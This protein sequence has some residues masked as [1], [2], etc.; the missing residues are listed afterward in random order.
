[1]TSP[2]FNSVFL[3]GNSESHARYYSVC[4]TKIMNMQESK[5]RQP[6]G[7]LKEL[8]CVVFIYNCIRVLLQ[9]APQ[10]AGRS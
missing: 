2:F 9:L 10:I 8:V 4:Y 7:N 5:E 6:E 1:M 3:L